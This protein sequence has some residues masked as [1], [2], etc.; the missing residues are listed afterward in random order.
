M[1]REERERKAIEEIAATL[2][3]WVGPGR[4]GAV[5]GSGLI[6]SIELDAL[7]VV[8]AMLM[9]RSNESEYVLGGHQPSGGDFDWGNPPNCGSAATRIE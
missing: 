9:R 5:F 1:K 7:K 4:A 2:D 3:E 8:H 6:V